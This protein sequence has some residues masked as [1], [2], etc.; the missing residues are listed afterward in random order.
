MMS[1][2]TR[3]SV[4]FDGIAVL[5]VVGGNPLCVFGVCVGLE[6]ESKS[7]RRNDGAKRA[8]IEKK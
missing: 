7:S 5:R 6:M 1:R 4:S 8:E 2:K 3:E